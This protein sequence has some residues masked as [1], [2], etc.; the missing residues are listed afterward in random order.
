MALKCKINASHKLKP[1]EGTVADG[2]GT[3]PKCLT[4]ERK[5]TTKG[6][7]GAHNVVV[8]VDVTIPVTDEGLRVGSP[9]EAAV[10]REMEGRKIS[11]RR[12]LVP[13]AQKSD[14]AVALRGPTLVPG[15]DLPP[16]QRPVDAP[17]DEVTDRRRDGSVRLSTTLDQPRGRDRFDRKITDVPEPEAPV[18]RSAKRRNRRKKLELS[19]KL[20]RQSSGERA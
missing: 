4:P 9:R 1:V 17:W 19:A 6:F 11:A 2:K 8:D 18:S 20:S 16:R 3:C 15:R 13:T 7:L 12:S 10:K 14:V 5:L